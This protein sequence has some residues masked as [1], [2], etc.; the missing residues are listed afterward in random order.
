MIGKA[1]EIK[2]ELLVEFVGSTIEDEIIGWLDK[3]PDA[4][5][6]DIKFAI[7]TNGENANEVY[8]EAL[9]LFKEVTQ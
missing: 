6:I 2:T 4:D 1:S 9:I 3:N 5:V 7:M 8:R